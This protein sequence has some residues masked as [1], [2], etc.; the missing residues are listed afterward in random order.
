MLSLFF[1]CRAMLLRLVATLAPT[2]VF[3]V[4]TFLVAAASTHRKFALPGC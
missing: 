4:I 1:F 2:I 3:I